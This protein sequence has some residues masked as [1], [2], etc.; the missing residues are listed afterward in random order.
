MTPQ[1]RWD[2]GM[3]IPFTQEIFLWVGGKQAKTK[4]SSR[5][6]AEEALGLKNEK[7]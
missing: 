1:V 4:N 2:A 3:D 5:G 7:K 6:R